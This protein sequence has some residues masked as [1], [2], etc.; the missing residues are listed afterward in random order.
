[1]PHADPRATIT[2]D[3]F[4]VAPELIGMPLA[5]PWRRGA[6]MQVD[7]VLVA[8][9][10]QAG[11]MVLSF[12][13][14][15]FFFWLAHRARRGGAGSGAGRVPLCTLGIL[16]LFLGS[17]MLGFRLFSAQLGDRVVSE[18][19]TGRFGEGAQQVG[20]ALRLAG[21]L[22]AVPKAATEAEAASA[23]ERAV[24]R[25]QG[26]EIPPEEI[27][28]KLAELYAE[29]PAERPWVR[30]A[31]EAAM[32]R[33]PTPPPAA[34]PTAAELAADF[35][36]SLEA[37]D[38]VA[39]QAA[40]TQLARVLAADTLRQTEARIAVLEARIDSLLAERREPRFWHGPLAFLRA[41]AED[42]G[43]GL[44]WSSLYF[45][46]FLVLWQGQ[47]PGKRLTGVRVLRLNGAPITW[48]MAF[49][50]F[51]G[52]AAG[53]ATGLLGF[54]QIYWDG[55]RQA[56]HDKVA[57]TVVVKSRVAATRPKPSEPAADAGSPHP[58]D[59]P[60][61]SSSSR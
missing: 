13:A 9:L 3:S 6:A 57:E 43:L 60:G 22:A 12:A 19:A 34:I 5:R 61:A 32:A 10:V 56:I 58:T 25:M 36:A 21:D 53:L 14:A 37:G 47:T 15:A 28:G 44:G 55:N 39:A 24:A 41:M 18:M 27:G 11:G 33:F 45:T 23:I 54:L 26:L 17:L 35:A 51:G 40:R 29:A 16:F 1:M 38:T 59:V 42:L 48:W 4:A 20:T 8:L 30:N 7:L 2:P 46:A 52:Y 31:L 50:R 49:E